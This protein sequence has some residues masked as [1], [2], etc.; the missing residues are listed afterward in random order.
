MQAHIHNQIR[1]IS[2][3]VNQTKLADRLGLLR[4]ASQG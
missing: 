4:V 1:Q 3:Q 2:P